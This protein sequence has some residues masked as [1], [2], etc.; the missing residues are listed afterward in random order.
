MKNYPRLRCL[1]SLS[2]MM[3]DYYALRSGENTERPVAYV[4]SGAPVEILE[5]LGI[6][7]I[8]PENY[9]ALCGARRASTPL[10]EIAESKGYP[11]D[12]CSYAKG[13]LAASMK[14]EKAP[15]GGLPPP[16]F[17][18]CCNNICQTVV[19]WY[20]ALSDY[21]GCPLFIVDVPFLNP[22]EKP[23]PVYLYLKSQFEELVPEIERIAQTRLNR[24]YL[25][26]VIY[27]SGQALSL[28]TEIRSMGRFKP[29]P[30]N[31][32]D[33]FMAMAPIVVMRGK[34]QA[35]S[36]YSEMLDELKRRVTNGTAAVPGER[37][38]L[39][40]DNIAIWPQL[41]PL[42]RLFAERDGCFVVD[43]YT[44]SWSMNFGSE[45]DPFEGMAKVYSKA[46]INLD[47]QTR[48][49]IIKCLARDYEVTGVVM[50][51]N[52][53]CKPFSLCQPLLHRLLNKDLGLPCLILE[54]DM[55]D[56]RAFNVNATKER[57]SA[58]MEIV[59][60]ISES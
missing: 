23:E 14:P 56:T 5:A 34:N 12:L 42:Y 46:F 13:H 22:K 37:F 32:P 58:F 33:L 8:Y 2:K 30:V 40:W 27:L 44:N 39:L 31:V 48:L 18:L 10:C 16:D 49:E 45:D 17:L 6:T 47:F 15:L 43:T 19:K 35:V 41:L 21:Y 38:R 36:F 54:A 20:Q 26:E 60:I 9:G 53:S 24:E 7:T 28:W 51:A 50:H 59:E 3:D 57:L 11:D 1:K 55:S 52:R 4:T 25:S 29:S